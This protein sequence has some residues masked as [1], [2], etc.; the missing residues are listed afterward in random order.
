MLRPLTL[1]ATLGSATA[2]LGACTPGGEVAQSPR[3]PLVHDGVSIILLG[4]GLV[5]FTVALHGPADATDVEMYGRCAAAGYALDQ[6]YGFARQVR[7]IVERDGR[8]WIGDAVY[9]LSATLPDGLVIID[10]E[11]VA[12][13]CNELGIP[14]A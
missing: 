11:V 13:D 10:A 9:T 1:L 4:D 8:T 6:G 2:A 5:S 12:S 14:T 3:Q 7:T